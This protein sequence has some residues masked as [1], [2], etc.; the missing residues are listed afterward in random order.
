MEKD[1]IIYWG[2]LSLLGAVSLYVIRQ[3]T[4]AE[5]I[6]SRKK[7]KSEVW[8]R[9]FKEIENKLNDNS[10]NP[11]NMENLEVVRIELLVALEEYIDEHSTQ[12]YFLR[13]YVTQLQKVENEKYTPK[14]KAIRKVLSNLKQP[15]PINKNE[16]E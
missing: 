13:K 16:N 3:A 2:V 7:I 5:E 6:D 14:I 15:I 12:D 10:V 8:Q 9:I 4:Q 11:N 1:G